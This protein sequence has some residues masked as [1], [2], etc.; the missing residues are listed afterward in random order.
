MKASLITMILVSCLG[1]YALADSSTHWG[2]EGDT[3]P[4]MWAELDD[5]FALCGLGVNQSPVN[6]SRFIEAELPPLAFRYAPKPPEVVNNGHTIQVNLDSS[7]EF[8]TETASYQLKQFHFHAPSEHLVDGRSYPIE[9]HF[10]HKNDQGELAVVGVF[11][12]EGRPNPE[13]AALLESIP[14]HVGDKDTSLPSLSPAGFLPKHQDYYRYSGSLT[15][16][17]CS[18]GVSWYVLKTPISASRLQIERLKTVL[19]SPNN[20]PPQPLNARSVMR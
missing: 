5:D 8:Y 2:Y 10:V 14:P 18:E 16:P 17:P 15:T 1:A 3:G 4:N 7:G 20:R 12:E 6:L 9:I 19:P 13:L 11:V